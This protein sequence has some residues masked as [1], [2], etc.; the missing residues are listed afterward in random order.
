MRGFDLAAVVI[1]AALAFGG[2]SMAV[3]AYGFGAVFAVIAVGL[4]IAGGL[5]GEFGE[6]PDRR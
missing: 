5:A 1:F 2:A 6:F 3:L 4:V